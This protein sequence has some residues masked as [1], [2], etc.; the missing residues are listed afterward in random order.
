MSLSKEIEFPFFHAPCTVNIHPEYKQ[1]WKYA[2]S[3]FT[4]V[5]LGSIRIYGPLYWLSAVF[6]GKGPYFWLTKSTLYTLRS[7]VFLGAY[8]GL[9]GFSG[10]KLMGLTGK[11]Y[12]INYFLAAFIGA[13]LAILIEKKFRRIELG[14]YTL[15]Q[16]I[17]VVF[18]MLV[19]RGF[20]RPVKHGLVLLFA[21]CFAILTYFYKHERGALGNN[22]GMLLKVILGQEDK[23]DFMEQFISAL[24]ERLKNAIVSKI[25]AKPQSNG[26]ASSNHSG[27]EEKPITRHPLCKHHD[28]CTTYG[29]FGFVKGFAMGYIIKGTIACLPLLSKTSILFDKQQRHEFFSAAWGKTT[30]K[31]GLFVGLLSSVTRIFQCLLRWLRNKDDGLNI[32]FSAFIAGLSSI[33]GKS[34]EISMYFVAKACEALF[35]A[36]ISRGILKPLPLGEALLFAVSTGILFYAA[37]FE[38]HN[39]RPS[40]L[41]FVFRVSLGKFRDFFRASA[42]LREEYQK[43]WYAQPKG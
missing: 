13:F 39:M 34:V 30:L 19:E 26:I 7:C 38:P 43:L 27:T 25:A 12:R 33:F 40:Y 17:E 4:H 31:F 20:L 29:P 16:A 18:H 36:L 3:L 9:F 14:L 32:G 23:P 11:N 2:W 10:C 41:A 37:T 35:N 42:N 1:C 15:N 28:S 22:I 5:F 8:T 6:A 24:Y 21:V